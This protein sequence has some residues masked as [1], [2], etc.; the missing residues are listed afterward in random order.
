MDLCQN[1]IDCLTF[2]TG[3]KG[4]SD[5]LCPLY[6][7]HAVVLEMASCFLSVKFSFFYLGKGLRQPGKSPF[8]LSVVH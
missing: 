6:L 8:Q 3:L 5:V 7:V 1:S 4:L 2:T